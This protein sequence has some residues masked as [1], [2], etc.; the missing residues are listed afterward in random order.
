MGNAWSVNPSLIA[1]YRLAPQWLAAGLLS[2]EAFGSAIRR[3][4][5]VQKTGRYDARVALGD[6]FR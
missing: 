4:P 6:V 2:Y 1:S 5:L 3:S